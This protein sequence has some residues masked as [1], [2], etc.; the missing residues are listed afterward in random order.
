MLPRILLFLLLPIL[1][2]QGYAGDITGAPAIVPPPV[3]GDFSF[4][5]S[6][7]FFGRGGESD[8]YRTQQLGL[9]INVSPGWNFVFDHSILTASETNPVLPGVAG[10]LDQLN[11]SL[12]YEL[13]QSQ[14]GANGLGVIEVGAGLRAYGDF[15]GARIQNSLHRLINNGTNGSAYVDTETNSG[16]F[17]LKGDYEKLYMLPLMN[18]VNT[19]W[20]AG[21]WL[22]ATGLVSTERQWDAALAANAVVRNHTTTLWLGIREDWRE[23]YD[24]DFVQQATA[25]SESGTSF[26]LGMGFGPVSFETV[27]GLEDKASFGR[28]IFTSVENEG[29]SSGASLQTNNAVVLNFLLPDVELELQYRRSLSACLYSLGRPKTWLVFGMHYGEPAYNSSLDIYNAIKQFAL[30][31]EFEW[32]AQEGYQ[33]LWPYLT[34]L[35]GQRSEQLK[36][37]I[38]TLAGEE[39]ETVSSMLFEVGTGIRFNLYQQNKWQL[40]FQVGLIGLY[41]F[42]SQTVTFDQAQ[43]E[44]LQPDLV[45]NLGFSLNYGF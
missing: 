39:S 10:R 20:Q 11:L 9:Q 8:D 4:L 36:A 44:L 29:T 18:E 6:N 28:L 41:P 2:R 31:V 45:V 12:G 7:D 13:Y 27:Q 1:V 37:D 19:S 30:G 40:L 42:A 5:W 17:W 24:L 14:S 16:I 23:N 33:W 3:L 35:A 21:Y 34:L 32:R 38:G 25:L 15:G 43:I 22:N 26:V